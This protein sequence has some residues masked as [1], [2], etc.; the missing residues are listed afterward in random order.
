MKKN[1]THT[2]GRFRKKMR[3]IIK[4]VAGIM[5]LIISVPLFIFY[6]VFPTL[7]AQVGPNQIASWI[8][9]TLSFFG[10][11][12]IIIGAGELEI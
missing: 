3:G 8:A 4:L 1:G 5:M 12:S 10:F 7:N 2:D 6:Q 9:V 11:V